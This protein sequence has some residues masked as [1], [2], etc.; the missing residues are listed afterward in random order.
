MQDVRLRTVSAVLLSLAA[1]ASL[2]GAAAAFLWWL[3]CSGRVAETLRVRMLLP[4]AAMLAFFS[5]VL[6][7]TGGDGISYFCRM[8]VIVLVG[9]WVYAEHKGGEFLRLGTWLFG[10]RTGFELGLLAETG[11]QALYLLV[12]DFSRIRVAEALKGMGNGWR[13]LV[14]A[15]LVLITGALLRAEQT[16]EL[17]AVR[18]YRSGGSLCPR[19]AVTT[20]DLSR[21]AAALCVSAIA[22]APVSAFF[23]LTR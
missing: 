4:V 6:L 7:L 11:M 23:I 3:A 10:Q 22:F 15:G 17:L 1:F 13:T 14:T 19:F 18:G 8:L 5:V 2:A 12:Q 9:F 21:F 16:T 20:G